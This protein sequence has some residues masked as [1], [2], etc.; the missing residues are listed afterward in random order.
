V[1]R[2]FDIDAERA[3]AARP[4]NLRPEVPVPYSVPQ[5]LFPQGFG[6]QPLPTISAEQVRGLPAAWRCL[7]F[8]GNGVASMS[9]LEA[10]ADDGVTVLPEQPPVCSRPNVMYG[11]FDWW[12]MST[13]YAV[14]RGNFVGVL[15]DFDFS[16]YPRQVVPVPV[17]LID[18]QYLLRGIPRYPIYGT[19]WEGDNAL[20]SADVVHVRGFSLPG[21]L[22]GVG[23]V[24]NF[25]R[26]LGATLEMQALSADTYHRAS[27][28]PGVLTTDRPRLQ[29]DDAEE[30]QQQWIEKHGLGQRVPAVLPSGWTFQPI[31]W[32]PEDAQFLEAREMSL[33]ETAL[34]FGLDPSDIGASF[35]GSSSSMTYANIEQREISRNVD[36]LMPLATRFEQ[37]WSD[38][39]PG[40]AKCRFNPDRRLRAD[41]K[42]RAEVHALNIDSGVETRDEARKTDGKPPLTAAEKRELGVAVDVAPNSAAKTDAT[43]GIDKTALP[44]AP[45]AL[46][47]LP[48]AT[49]NGNGSGNGQG[50]NANG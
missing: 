13:A 15:V 34:M 49:S 6:T 17:E 26:Q 1:A 24:E 10:I 38:I 4:R 41:S 23:V 16:F 8:L 25:R 39:I 35:P 29:E 48:A 50:N 42:T 46:P 44:G 9:P 14:S 22:W 3:R 40:N 28:P 37:A 21:S 18:P 33:A 2:I 27:V 5:L 31:A 32:T 20:T 43:L 47:A 45:A 30:V 36:A 7:N 19:Q 12:H 11:A